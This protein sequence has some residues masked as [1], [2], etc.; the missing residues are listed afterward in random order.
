MSS[1]D[2]NRAPVGRKPQR[3]VL[4]QLRLFA[5]SLARRSVRPA[6][7]LIAVATA[8]LLAADAPAV[9]VVLVPVAVVHRVRPDTSRASSHTS[10][11][12]RLGLPRCTGARVTAPQPTRMP[13]SRSE[14]SRCVKEQR[15]RGNARRDV[16]LLG[17]ARRGG[18]R[19]DRVGAATSRGRA[20]GP[21]GARSTCSAR[22]SRRRTPTGPTRN[23][24]PA[25]AQTGSC[26]VSRRSRGGGASAP[27]T[28]GPVTSP[29]NSDS[30]TGAVQR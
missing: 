1:T 12:R 16:R 14:R 4:A 23:Q 2:R 19:P 15:E 26:R 20:R 8:M 18:G 17:G 6:H 3:P 29:A 22:P 5:G 13:T 28:A 21:A 7:W 27:A 25:P 30:R 24:P 11:V 9:V 10:D